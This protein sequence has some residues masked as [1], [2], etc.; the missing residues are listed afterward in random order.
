MDDSTYKVKTGHPVLG[1]VCGLLGIA[2]AILLIFFTGVIGTAIAIL[3]G[4]IAVLLGRGARRS[5]K[6]LG[7][8]ITG[9]IAIML[10]VAMMTTIL[11]TFTGMHDKAASSGVAPLMAEYSSNP[12]FGL[13]GIISKIPDD[14]SI[15][16]L[17]KEIELLN[18]ME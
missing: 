9:G 17:M 5:G 1:I 8:I 10:S 11:G 18:S 13:A 3:F 2:C 14:G 6:G 7:A 16:A 15:D 12:Y 4:V